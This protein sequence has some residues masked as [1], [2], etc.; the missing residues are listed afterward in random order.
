MHHYTLSAALRHDRLQRNCAPFL[1]ILPMPVAV[2]QVG[3]MRVRVDKWR[4]SM[5]VCV[6]F[7]GR[8]AG[9]MLVLVMFVMHVPVSM[10][11][12]LVGVPMLVLFR[13]MEPDPRHHQRARPQKQPS[14][15]LLQQKHTENRP[16]E[17]SR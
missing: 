10:G 12:R 1:S 11:H 13:Q 4:V 8:R 6:R 14:E 3:V 2:V 5:L 9:R 15:R 7:S 16:D 17:G